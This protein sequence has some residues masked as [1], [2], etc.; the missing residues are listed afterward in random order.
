MW[1]TECRPRG[2]T[3]AGRAGKEGEGPVPWWD[4][5][6]IAP[7]PCASM[8]PAVSGRVLSGSRS[9]EEELAKAGPVT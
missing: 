6:L 4:L 7:L 1:R 9:V 2:A 3:G 5:G 8:P